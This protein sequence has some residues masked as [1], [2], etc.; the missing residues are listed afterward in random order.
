MSILSAPDALGARRTTIE[1][2]E[3]AVQRSSARRAVRERTAAVLYPLAATVALFALWEV[4]TIVFAVPT[5]LLPRPSI[6]A[7]ALYEHADLLLRETWVTALEILLG[8]GLSIVV[9]LPLALALFL[10]PPF[11]RAV[12]PLL[13]STQAMPKVA[14]APLLIVWFGFGLLPKV[15]IAFLIAFFPVVINAVMGLMAIEREKIYLA[16]SMGLGPLATFWKIRLP[17]ALPAIFGGLKISITLAVVGAVVG[18]FVGGNAGVGYQLI[19][20][21]GSMDTALLFAEL[22]VL[23][24][25]GVVFFMLVEFVERLALPRRRGAA[26]GAQGTM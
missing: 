5:F 17:D 13:V 12:Y 18:E 3:A 10:W 7:A 26:I 21:N 1:D 14:L 19:V 20:A 6:V 9:G 11:S 15:L 25:I 22:I 24:I 23:T 8:Y 2:V 16:Q 4:L